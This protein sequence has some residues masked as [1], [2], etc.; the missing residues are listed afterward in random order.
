MM[1]NIIISFCIGLFLLSNNVFATE[2]DNEN[3]TL[4]SNYIDPGHNQKRGKDKS[5]IELYLGLQPGSFGL[6]LNSYM[7]SHGNLTE[8]FY[9]MTTMDFNDEDPDNNDGV[10]TDLHAKI[11]INLNGKKKYNQTKV[12]PLIRVK[13]FQRWRYIQWRHSIEIGYKTYFL[14]PEET[15]AEKKVSTNYGGLTFGYSLIDIADCLLFLNNPFKRI[16]EFYLNFN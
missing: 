5:P 2:N 1:K 6:K 14:D 15:T 3:T 10:E 4:Y 7:G 8:T 12:N 11:G 9:L 16:T 13:F